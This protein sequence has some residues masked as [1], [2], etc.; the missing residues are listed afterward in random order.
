MQA[1]PT[2]CSVSGLAC[3]PDYPYENRIFIQHL[4]CYTLKSVQPT[5]Q[6]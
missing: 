5:G 1:M 2:V 3:H 4:F 6:G